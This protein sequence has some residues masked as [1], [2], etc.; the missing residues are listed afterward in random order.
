MIRLSSQTFVDK[1]KTFA[2]DQLTV[3]PQNYIPHKVVSKWF[4]NS[5]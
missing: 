1:D 5:E 3:M 4:P 2:D